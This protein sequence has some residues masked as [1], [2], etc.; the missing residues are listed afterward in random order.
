METFTE[1]LEIQQQNLIKYDRMLSEDKNTLEEVGKMIPEI[2]HFND[3]NFNFR[4]LN[5]KGCGWFGVKRDKLIKMGWGFVTKFYHPDTIEF[6][7]P[8]IKHYCKY[9]NCD[10]I[11]SGY[12]KIF[13]P[14]IKDFVVCLVFVKKCRFL[15]GSLGITQPIE[16][17]LNISKKMNRIISEENFKQKH[18]KDFEFLTLREI[19]ILKLLAEGLNNPRISDQL[20]ISRRTVEQHRKNINRKLQIHTYRDIMSYAY[21]FD[22]I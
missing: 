11:Y 8:K 22:L 19:E 7:I 5:E 13:D 12:Q 10:T 16:K 2:F 15:P 1:T 4:F 9:Q 6:E 20:Y 3:H 21:A 18:A 14:R 17:V